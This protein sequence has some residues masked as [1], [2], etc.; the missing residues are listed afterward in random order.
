MAITSCNFTCTILPELGSVFGQIGSRL[1]YGFRLLL[2]RSMHCYRTMCQSQQTLLKPDACF[3]QDY[4]M[5]DIL[6]GV[7]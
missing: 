3:Y 1:G 4:H 2:A 7:D 6:N 5:N